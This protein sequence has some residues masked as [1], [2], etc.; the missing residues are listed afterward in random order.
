MSTAGNVVPIGGV[1]TAPVTG[2]TSRLL[3]EH[4]ALT[5][6]TKSG[7][8]KSRRN[9]RL[10]RA[11]SPA[12]V[13]RLSAAAAHPAGLARGL[14]DAP[15]SP[16]LAP[17]TVY[18]YL[19]KITTKS[20]SLFCETPEAGKREMV[21]DMPNTEDP[22]V[23]EKKLALVRD[24]KSC[25]QIEELTKVWNDPNYARRLAEEGKTPAPLI[26]TY[27]EEGKM[28]DYKGF[29]GELCTAIVCPAEYEGAEKDKFNAGLD[30]A[31]CTVQRVVS[32][33]WRR[34]RARTRVGARR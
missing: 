18:E 3:L 29:K 19:Y 14:Q 2:G 8:Y 22:E 24:A 26:I 9:R 6:N 11:Y 20:A 17:E 30:A 25:D 7:L 5:I 1:S 21:I 4:G 34:V 31:I 28:V 27:C 10:M 33:E 23:R 15:E 13:R 32:S 16:L 12:L